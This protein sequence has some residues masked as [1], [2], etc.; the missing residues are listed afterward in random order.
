MRRKRPPWPR[1]TR[2]PGALPCLLFRWHTMQGHVSCA[3]SASARSLISERLCCLLPGSFQPPLHIDC[4][5]QVRS[6]EAA[7]QQLE[8]AAE[9]AARRAAAA[10]DKA[11]AVA[12]VMQV[13]RCLQL[14]LCGAVS[15]CRNMLRSRCAT[16]LDSQHCTRSV[17]K[18]CNCSSATFMA[19]DIYLLPLHNVH[20]AT[21]RSG[22]RWSAS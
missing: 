7:A 18:P 14:L 5:K 15:C 1:G 3:A 2:V 6:L 13:P 19:T 17:R 22:R 4:R 21:C 12:Q 11:A 20:A 8:E 10:E 16:P 9:A